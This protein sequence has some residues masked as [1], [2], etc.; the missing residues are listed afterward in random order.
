MPIPRRLV[1]TL[2]LTLLPALAG[3]WTPYDGGPYQ[4]APG[5]AGPG[6]FPGDM[7]QGLPQGYGPAGPS[8]PMTPSDRM[9]PSGPGAMDL[10][11]APMTP[12]LTQMG[13]L[14]IQRS[15][16]DQAY[17]LTI[18]LAGV[19]PDEVRVEARGPRLLVTRDR[20]TEASQEETFTDGRGYRR[21]F[22]YSS[23]RVSRRFNVPPDGDTSAMQR[24]DTE[25]A[26]YVT[27]PRTANLMPAP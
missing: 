26:I 12:P 4:P 14:R 1:G 16:T 23:G 17:L 20:S 5:S 8:G 22:S 21:S 7:H 24:R 6:P 10:P 9:G 19:K 15:A 27:I 11:P 3:A 25:E 18:Y 2:F 13:G